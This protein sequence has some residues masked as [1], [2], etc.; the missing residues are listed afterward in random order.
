VTESVTVSVSE[1]VRDIFVARQPIFDLESRLVGYELLYR[2]SFA[3]VAAGAGDDIG[4][5]GMILVNSVLGIGLDELT[6][7]VRAWVNFPRE[8]L[9][10]HD[11][12]L[13]DPRDYVI[14]LLE[15]VSC[16]DETVAACRALRAKGFLLAL[17]DF[18]AGEEYD[19]IVQLAQI[20]KIGVL[21]ETEARLRATVARFAPSSVQLLA[22][23]IEDK[24]TYTL[25]RKLGF[26]LF[27]GFYFSHPE[28]VRRKDLPAQMISIARL[29]NLVL[30]GNTRDS[31]L[32]REF[33]AD[34][35]LS[36]KLLKIVNSA[37]AG[38]NGIES[39]QHAVQMVGRTPLHRWL[40]LLFA[41]AAPRTDGVNQELVLAAL[42]RGRMCELLA[43]R[44]GR[45]AAAASLFL[46][47]LLSTFDSIL[48][49]TMQELLQQ[50][51]VSAEVEAA[52]LREEGP[53]TPYL[54]LATSYARAQWQEAM[55]LGTQM[56][57]LEELTPCYMEA[58]GWARDLLMQH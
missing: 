17:D 30:D 6:G 37:A 49:V 47:G 22:E 8:L 36:F 24:E 55:E 31:D 28:T 56:G 3:A 43:Q 42:E 29:M 5:T 45:N 50:V 10:K 35:G 27:Q 33:R 41:S 46:T 9:L 34:P 4:M 20:V 23:K 32:E 58:S 53:Y 16:D 2:P 48:N 15:T 40:A 26:S 54:A 38:G 52:L 13:L 11:F 19:P 7:G 25:C 21:G 44:S 57:L 1:S 39:V 51:S 12:D 18:T 14:E